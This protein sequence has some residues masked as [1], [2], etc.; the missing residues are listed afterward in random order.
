MLADPGFV[1]VELVQP[2]D[3]LHV[4]LEGENRILL[5]RDVR[6]DEGA[7]TK[8]WS[9]HGSSPTPR[10]HSGSVERG[11]AGI[12]RARR[13][14]AAGR[15]RGIEVLSRWALDDLGPLHRRGANVVDGG[16]ERDEDCERRK[17]SVKVFHGRSP[18]FSK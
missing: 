10:R 5:G 16:A 13:Q 6:R 3:E 8:P 14:Q 4:V 18:L 1:V 17:N 2:L 15:A 11:A 9:S 12:A 7:E